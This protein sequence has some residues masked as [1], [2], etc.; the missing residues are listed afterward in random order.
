MSKFVE[1]H[2]L[3][4]LSN[5]RGSTIP[6]EYLSNLLDV[7]KSDIVME[8]LKSPKIDRIKVPL[9]VWFTFAINLTEKVDDKERVI[10]LESLLDKSTFESIEKKG[11]GPWSEKFIPPESLNE[12]CAEFIWFSLGSPNSSDRWY[13]AHCLRLLAQF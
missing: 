7:S 8:L 11:D 6:I 5:K 2:A 12:I 9:N 13:A 1:E 4:L 3:Y 10:A